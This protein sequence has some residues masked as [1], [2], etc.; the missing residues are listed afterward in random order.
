M[1]GVI[2][3]IHMTFKYGKFYCVFSRTVDTSFY[4]TVLKLTF[5]IWHTSTNIL[6]KTKVHLFIKN[7][8]LVN[9][10]Y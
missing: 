1:N 2:E 9:T 7:D 3:Y 4:L 8:N 5:E 6:E 10:D